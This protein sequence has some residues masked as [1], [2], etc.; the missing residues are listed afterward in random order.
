MNI[1]AVSRCYI[2]IWWKTNHS[3]VYVYFYL[4]SVRACTHKHY[5]PFLLDY[6]VC[7]IFTKTHWIF[8][9]TF[10]F[11]LSCLNNKIHDLL[12]FLFNSH[13][14]R[15]SSCNP[16]YFLIRHAS[17]PE[18]ARLEG[19]YCAFIIFIFPNKY[20]AF[21]KQLCHW[22]NFFFF[23]LSMKICQPLWIRMVWIKKI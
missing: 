3:R 9:S 5:C 19:V 1:I 7:K 13:F 11:F 23:F 14:S 21:V 18:H 8:T 12:S 16:E 20:R 17:S 10:S 2:Y 22:R 15:Y 6:L 4:F